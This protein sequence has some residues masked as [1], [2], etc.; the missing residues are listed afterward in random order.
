MKTV[1]LF[2]TLITTGVTGER[3]GIDSTFKY[4]VE[5]LESFG[6]TFVVTGAMALGL[7]ARPRYSA[8]IDLI[9]LVRSKNALTQTSAV[10]RKPV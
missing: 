9:V 3:T 5:M 4:I 2:E 8:D 6:I 1:H 10:P 7:I